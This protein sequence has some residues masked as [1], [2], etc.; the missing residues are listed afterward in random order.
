MKNEKFIRLRK[1]RK[2]TQSALAEQTGVPVSAIRRW[3]RGEAVPSGKN[4]KKMSDI[5][6][7]KM[8][9][10]Q[11]V[12]SGNGNAEGKPGGGKSGAGSVRRKSGAGSDG[13]KTGKGKSGKSGRKKSG[14]SEPAGAKN[15]RRGSG[16]AEPTEREELENM[17]YEMLMEYLNDGDPMLR[18]ILSDEILSDGGIG[19]QE[20][21]EKFDKEYQTFLDSFR[22][23][24]S[25]EGFF[26]LMYIFSQ[27]D[28]PGTI[29]HGNLILPFIRVVPAQSAQAVFLEDGS[30]NRIVFM[31]NDIIDM[32]PVSDEYDVYTLDV[33]VRYPVFPEDGHVYGGEEFHQKIRLSFFVGDSITSVKREDYD[34]RDREL[35]LPVM[36]MVYDVGMNGLFSMAEN[37]R[38]YSRFFDMFTAVC[39]VT[40]PDGQ[41]KGYLLTDL[42]EDEEEEEDD[43]CYTAVDKIY[44]KDT[45]IVIEIDDAVLQMTE[46]N[47]S[48]IL[49]VDNAGNEFYVAQIYFKDKKDSLLI[50]DSSLMLAL[51]F[52]SLDPEKN[53]A[54]QTE[55]GVSDRIQRRYRLKVYPQG[56]GRDVYRVIEICGQDTLD[57]LCS[58]IMES[59][60]FIHEHLYE[61]CMSEKMHHRDNYMPGAK[62][63]RSTEISLDRL[64][65]SESQKFWLHYDFG[66]DWMFVISVQKIL[67]VPSYSEPAVIRGKG[68]VEQYPEWEFF[69]EEEDDEDDDEVDEVDEDGEDGPF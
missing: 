40:G 52:A 69:D 13:A 18:D 25:T 28:V 63:G 11:S 65:L 17:L 57:D 21:W 56:M 38:V 20:E 46:E 48:D 8:R 59:F 19:L 24:K 9:E 49:P 23:C 2:M 7:V 47:V 6:G 26:E 4:M 3:E 67:E 30:A 22:G 42:P 10:I 1:D 60:D 39:S 66:D 55:N 31:K 68:D 15:V 45:A 14:G 32:T 51:S 62:S 5:F 64:K 58:V 43:I 33:T 27:I 41:V 16:G 35:L 54:Q 44:R 61:F 50:K 36:R 34:P 53:M 37:F 12:F 29:M